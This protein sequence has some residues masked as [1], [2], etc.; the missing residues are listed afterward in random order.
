MKK[1]TL[2]TAHIKA[3]YFSLIL[4]GKKHFEIRDTSPAGAEAIIFLDDNSGSYLGAYRIVDILELRRSDDKKAVKLSGISRDQFYRLFP[5]ESKGGSSTLWA[6]RLG[7][8]T[9]ISELLGVK[10][11]DLSRRSYQKGSV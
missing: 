9:T 10:Q 7:A 5:C 3:A 1:T 11:S 4:E 6:I 2:L 8:R